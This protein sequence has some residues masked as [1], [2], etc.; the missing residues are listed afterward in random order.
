MTKM[1]ESWPAFW[2]GSDDAVGLV[3]SRERW[4]WLLRSLDIGLDD[5]MRHAL[6]ARMATRERRYSIEDGYTQAQ[7]DAANRQV[8]MEAS[9][10]PGL[11]SFGWRREHDGEVTL[12]EWL[13]AQGCDVVPEDWRPTR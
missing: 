8:A 13:R 9:T 12:G 2:W 4:G 3:D 10:R 5:A 7:A 1:S 6:D 11:P